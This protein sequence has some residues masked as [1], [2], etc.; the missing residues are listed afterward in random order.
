MPKRIIYLVFFLFLS[1]S[2]SLGS[3]EQNNVIKIDSYIFGGMK[4]RAIG[5]A[6]MSGRITSIDV[7]NND[8]NIIYVGTAGGGVWKSESGGITFF[9]IFDEHTQSIGTLKID[10]SNPKTVWVGTGEHNVRNS[11]SVGTGIYKTIDGGESWQFMGLGNSERISSIQI[12]PHNSN[13]V[14]VGV[15]GHLWNANEERGVYKTTDGG[16]TWK[17]ILRVNENTGC[18][19][20]SMDPNN[21]K[22]LYA[23]MWE[24]MRQPHTF[25]SGGPGSNLYRSIDGGET[26]EILRKGLPEGNLGRITVSVAPSRPNIIYAIVE[27]EKTALYRSDDLGHN[28]KEMNSS[29]SVAGRPFYFGHLYVDPKNHDR[30]YKPGQSLSISENGGRTFS[31][32]GGGVHPDHHAIWV[33]PDE[34]RHI[35]LGTDGG[36][37]ES[38]DRGGTWIFYKN[39]PVSQFYRVSYDMDRPYN[40]YGGLQDNGSW[41]APSKGLGGISNSDWKNIGG[42]DGFY[43]LPDP[44]DNDIIYYE[45]QGGNIVRRHR[46]TN[47]TK[48]IKPFPKDGEKKYRFNWN[49]PIAFSPSKPGVMYFGSQYLSRS[50]DSGE[51]WQ[52]IS[53]DLTTNDPEK[54]KQN[55]SGGL[56]ID[57]S[58]AENHCTIYTIS[59]S[60]KD[61]MVIWAGTDDGNLQVT[62]NNGNSWSN[63]VGNINNL[64]KNTWCSDVKASQH[65]RNT[66]YA[67]FDG[68]R[69]GDKN[70]YVFK[71]TD[72]GKTWQSIA[73]EAVE[74]Y[75]LDI[76][77]DYVNPNLLF[78]GTEFG[79]FVSVDGGE[80]WVRFKGNLPKVGIREIKIHPRQADL[81]LATHGRGIYILDDITPLRQVSQE[82]LAANVSLFKSRP[83]TITSRSGRQQFNGSD[84]FVGENP[85]EVATITYYLK[86]R[87]L[88][89]DL[90]IDIFNEEGEF[91]KSL[92][93]GKRRGINRVEWP[94]RLKAPRTPVSRS[95]RGGFVF[96]PAVN[97]GVYTAR[98]IKSSDTLETKIEV[99]HDPKYSHSTE[100]RDLQ[101]KTMWK[102]YGMQERLAYIAKAATDVRDDARER[103][104]SLKKNDRLAKEL[105]KFADALDVLYKTLVVTERTRGITNDERIRER[106]VSLFGAVNSY[107]GRPTQTQLDRAKKLEK[108]L[109]SADASFQS[110]IAK[111]L[112]PLNEKL[113]KKEMETIKILT[114]E[115]F[116]EQE[117]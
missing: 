100:D 32:R 31:G 10:Q 116:K 8:K 76:C 22:I 25:N 33:N 55:E 90:K 64:P 18:S 78:L 68:H 40:V 93:G 102:L 12:D 7:V 83:T 45:S 108:E 97:P 71:T 49:S 30:V 59:E 11:V 13:T 53:G 57:N 95:L 81:I 43:V 84:Q 51:S 60:P 99:F 5:P 26:W 101:Q 47:E 85:T 20:L 19:S 42:G 74:G 117:N 37:Y 75:A 113:T 107:G 80:H 88:F 112:N 38:R 92:S 66:A 111:D 24:F 23:G 115:E 63:V 67:V 94:M 29:Q 39:L 36:I 62:S 34:T 1:Q 70:V 96:G 52:T 21:P 27:A 15:L 89:G 17:H 4:A 98:L 28:W 109:E 82:V 56:T 2:N 48:Q 61:P 103:S 77:E 91:I 72:L 50:N 14:Y 106:V 79:L 54:Q 3:D 6:V 9:P 58:T 41:I 114:E 44:S 65:D 105:T 104:N 110:I 69:N 46:S 86:K 16:K 35:L 87:H 73:T